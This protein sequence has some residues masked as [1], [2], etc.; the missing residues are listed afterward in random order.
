M[1]FDLAFIV[2]VFFM[3]VINPEIFFKIFFPSLKNLAIKVTNILWLLLYGYEVTAYR[4]SSEL[5][6]WGI[7]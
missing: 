2:T 7:F 5:V 6:V 3:I 4:C 1:D